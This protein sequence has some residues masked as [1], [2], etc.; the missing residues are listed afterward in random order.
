MSLLKAL[1]SVDCSWMTS[2]F[3][4]P[5]SATWRLSSSWP[6]CLLRPTL[7]FEPIVASNT[8]RKLKLTR[9]MWIPPQTFESFHLPS[10]LSRT[11]S[12]ICP[13]ISLLST[14]PHKAPVLHVVLGGAS[15]SEFAWTDI[16]DAGLNCLTRANASMMM[17]LLKFLSPMSLLTR[18]VCFLWWWEQ[19][20]REGGSAF[21]GDV[22]LAYLISCLC[23]FFFFLFCICRGHFLF[24]KNLR[25]NV[26]KC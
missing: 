11:Q 5:F 13:H 17:I 14:S 2:F 19:K 6:S 24:L 16:M 1:T 26:C 15:H 7:F 21:Y 12:C 9:A 22:A 20:G 8:H 3:F 4:L 25:N 10:S 23:V 18:V